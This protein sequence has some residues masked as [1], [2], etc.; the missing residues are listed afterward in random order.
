MHPVAAECTRG[1][2]G[3][4]AAWRADGTG[5]KDPDLNLRRILV[6][7][8]FKPLRISVSRRRLRPISLGIRRI[9]KNGCL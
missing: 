1:R 7:N 5:P 9:Y 4:Y 8:G 6:F 2:L 3:P